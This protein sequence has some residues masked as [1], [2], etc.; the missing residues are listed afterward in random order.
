[1][2]P[3]DQTLKFGK[4]ARDKITGFTGILVARNTFIFGCDQWGIAPKISSE[5]KRLETEYFD[6]GRIEIIGD[7]INPSEVQSK[8]IIEQKQE[9]K[10]ETPQKVNNPLG[11]NQYSGCDGNHKI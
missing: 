3:I 10:I 11:I 6:D 9:S 1:M 7:G 8:P 5:G 2:K 4:Q